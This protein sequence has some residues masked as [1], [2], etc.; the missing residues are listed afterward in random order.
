[1]QSYLFTCEKSRHILI[2]LLFH[3]FFVAMLCFG[4][5]TA[6]RLGGLI[7]SPTS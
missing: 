2:F 5:N 3:L 1:M 7:T 4:L 6:N